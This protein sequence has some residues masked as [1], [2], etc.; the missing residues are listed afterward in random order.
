MQENKYKLVIFTPLTHSD[1]VREALGRAGAGVIGNYEYCSFSSI[2]YGR[3]RGNEKSNP[4]IGVAGN[5]EKV[6]EERIEVIVNE[7]IL[8]T[9]IAEVKKVHPY[10]EVAFDVYKLESYE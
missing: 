2:G 9:V 6:E 8:K 1:V 10:E 5:Y 4:S 3:Y 7:N